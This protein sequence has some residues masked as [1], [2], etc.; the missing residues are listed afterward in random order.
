MSE[1]AVYDMI[2][3][4]RLLGYLMKRP[5]PV[6]GRIIRLAAM[7]PLPPIATWDNAPEA[8][9][10]ITHFEF[11]YGARTQH[12]EDGWRI[13]TDVVLNTTATLKELTWL[14]DFRLPHETPRA[15]KERLY[16]SAYGG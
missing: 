6:R 12:S 10:A 8:S 9:V 11:T 13:T 2:N 5:G 3:P 4:D 14:R 1:V 7:P 15:A 16:R